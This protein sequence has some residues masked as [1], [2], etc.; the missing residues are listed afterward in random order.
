MWDLVITFT[1]F[2]F[3]PKLSGV[4]PKGAKQK[5]EM[6]YVLMILFDFWKIPLATL[7]WTDWEGCANRRKLCASRGI[8]WEPMTW[9]WWEMVVVWNLGCGC[10]NGGERHIKGY[11]RGKII[12]TKGRIWYGEMMERNMLSM[13]SSHQLAGF[14]QVVPHFGF[15]VV[16]FT[17]RALIHP[18]LPL[19]TFP[20]HHLCL[21][22][23]HAKLFLILF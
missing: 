19:P 9:S 1:P 22:L 5:S 12:G 21:S 10:V 14:G 16:A 2:K 15:S 11:I 7:W 8:R 6:K 4:S 3:H 20:A 13:I 18:S 23:L 17:S